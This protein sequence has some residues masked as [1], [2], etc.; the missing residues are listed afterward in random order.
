MFGHPSATASVARRM[1]AP[2]Q[3]VAG[4]SAPC[5]VAACA[6][7]GTCRRGLL[8]WIAL[9]LSADSGAADAGFHL[10][11]AWDTDALFLRRPSGHGACRRGRRIPAAL[12]ARG[13]GRSGSSPATR[14]ACS[15]RARHAVGPEPRD[16]DADPRNAARRHLR[17][18]GARRRG[19]GAE[20]ERAGILRGT[21]L[22]VRRMIRRSIG[23][24]VSR[25]DR[26]AL[27]TADRR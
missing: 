25:F 12:S 18:S 13:A 26:Q 23:T 10:R 8:V 15:F 22:S 1:Y 17:H 27:S 14:P 20:A 7:I 21:G 9:S 16:P 4:D 11:E 3:Y 2:D 19:G 24:S 5:G 6:R